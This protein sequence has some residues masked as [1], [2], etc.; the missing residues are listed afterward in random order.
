MAQDALSFAD[1]N[2]ALL[3]EFPK[4]RERFPATIG[5]FPG[6]EPGPYVVFGSVFTDY[7]TMTALDDP[8]LRSRIGLFIERMA[9][10]PDEDIEQLL[11]VEV[12]PAV[13]SS[14]AVVNTFWP[15]LGKRTKDLLRLLGP[16]T[17][18]DILL[19]PDR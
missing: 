12:L 9:T 7:V 1:L 5:D 16:L 18:P 13:L 3:E 17:S 6:W 10:S 11:R 8:A 15:H 4:L 2:H 14:Q 19:P